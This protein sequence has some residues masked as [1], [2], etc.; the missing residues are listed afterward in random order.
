MT[1]LA[2]FFSALIGTANL[3]PIAPLGPFPSLDIQNRTLYVPFTTIV[4]TLCVATMIFRTRARAQLLVLLCRRRRR[5]ALPRR[6]RLRANN[7]LLFVTFS[8]FPLSLSPFLPCIL[9]SLVGSAVPPHVAPPIFRLRSESG[10]YSQA[11]LLPPA[12]RGG[13]PVLVSWPLVQMAR[14]VDSNWQCTADAIGCAVM[15]TA[16]LDS[17]LSHHFFHGANIFN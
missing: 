6:L 14:L 3:H 16:R 11:S 10:A 1:S 13:T 4:W 7:F 8:I 12:L 2:Y 17:L 5:S 15:I 9:V